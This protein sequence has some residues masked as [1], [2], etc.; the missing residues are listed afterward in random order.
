MKISIPES[1]DDIGMSPE[2]FRVYFSLLRHVIEHE[3][4][5]TIDQITAKCFRNRRASGKTQARL[6]L[7]ELIKLGMVSG[8]IDTENY[9]LVHPDKWEVG[10]V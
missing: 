3:A 9:V 1:V 8:D 4:F 2:A 7:R 10:A 5:P 6:A